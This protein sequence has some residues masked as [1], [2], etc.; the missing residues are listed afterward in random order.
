MK[1]RGVER[2]KG[3]AV[4]VLAVSMLL[5]PRA[6]AQMPSP[7]LIVLNKADNML[8]IVDPATAKITGRVPTG[9][10]PHEVAVTGD[11]R[12]AYVANY[13]DR[14]PGKTI[15]VIDLASQKELDRVDLAGLRRPHGIQVMDGKV[16]FTAE[17]DHM[18]GRYDPVAKKVDL[19]LGTGQDLSHMVLCAPDARRMFTSNIGS[20]SITI[21][22]RK[23]DGAGWAGTAVQVGKG[24]EGADLAPDGKEFWTANSGDGTVSIVDVGQKKVV[25]TVDLKTRHSNRLK[26]TTDG[27]RVLVSDPPAGEVVVLEASS[28]KETAR[29]KVGNGPE[30]ILITPDGSTAYVA[31]AEDNVV[32]VLDLKTLKVSGH[33]AT[34]GGPDGMAWIPGK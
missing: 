9:A 6:G 2:F 4:A 5:L 26:F 25:Q 32:V 17:L 20:N 21:F 34:G 8:V 13:G 30:G 15:S 31:T 22:E 28:R 7:A 11:G 14:E 1:Y 3:P 16:Y 33:I 19:Q 27:K 18:V 12:T 24:P 29:I 10:G 23:P